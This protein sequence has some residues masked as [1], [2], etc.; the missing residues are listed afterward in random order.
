MQNNI[1]SNTSLSSS[2]CY[3]D[4]TEAQTSG[5]KP[6]NLSLTSQVK[7]ATHSAE[8]L[9]STRTRA[10]LQTSVSNP[11]SPPISVATTSTDETQKQS[12]GKELLSPQDLANKSFRL[13][14][15]NGTPFVGQNDS[16]SPPLRF[17]A[18]LKISGAMGN[19]FL[20]QATLNG[21][22][23]KAKCLGVTRM[24]P[25]TQQLGQ[26][27]VQISE[28]LRAGAKVS[29]DGYQLTLTSGQYTLTYLLATP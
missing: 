6:E 25:R 8:I 16:S 4:R 23:L 18:N 21:D 1:S 15:V 9:A 7:T 19:F 3:I 20:G 12:S 11:V 26:L 17:D 27:N 2:R 14:S 28:M 22:Q 24:A 29:F 5:H 10:G 13:Q